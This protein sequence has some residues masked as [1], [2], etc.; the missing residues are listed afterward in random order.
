MTPP[1]ASSKHPLLDISPGR[2]MWVVL[3]VIFL[4]EVGERL[5]LSNMPPISQPAQVFFDM[6]SMLLVLLPAYFLFFR[7]FQAQWHQRQRIEEELRKSEQR[8]KFALE[9]TND[10]LWDWILPTDE[11]Y[12]S[13]R[14]QTMLGYEVGEL[15]ASYHTWESRIHPEDREKTVQ[16]L[17][18][19]MEGRSSDYVTEQRLKTKGGE[20]IWVLD[21]GRVVEWDASGKASRL[22][23]T[24]TDITRRKQAE[25]E[26]HLLWQ[27]LDRASENERARLAR[28]LH[29][30][31][32]Q[33]V[34]V[35]Q[36][37][38]GVFKHS[39]KDSKHVGRCRTLIDLTTQI[40]NEI[41]RVTARLRPPALDTGLV[42]ALEYDLEGLRPHV[43]DLRI[44]LHAP[45]LERERLDT[46]SEITLFRIYQ[47]AL[48]N[49]IKHAQAGTIDIELQREDSE[50]ILTVR[51][52]GVG[53]EQQKLAVDSKPRGIGLVGMRE[54]IT[55]LGGHLE[56]STRPSRGTAVSAFLP[57]R[58]PKSR[59]MT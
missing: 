51:D 42:P 54:R 32:G 29:D 37:E 59:E 21:R 18:D 34:T 22:T 56:I 36:L 24:H 20:Y 2:L 58:P 53:F 35:L 23:G 48:T 7:P 49:A 45:G 28:D 15:E 12:F 33:L 41:R 5:L 44:S 25:A 57:Y 9:A 47:E 30:Q 43:L 27:Q 17:L 26:I 46:E 10:G 6:A 55:A 4:A 16:A 1:N 38:I 13:P 52:D 14:W 39:L 31:L 50:V 8:L 40:S 3:L 19:H 11:V